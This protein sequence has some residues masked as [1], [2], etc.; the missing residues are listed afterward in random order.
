MIYP[1]L[2]TYVL[3][4]Y[5]CKLSPEM[6]NSNNINKLITYDKIKAECPDI[7]PF[8]EAVNGLGFLQAVHHFYYTK[9][10]IYCCFLHPSVPNFLANHY[11]AN[12]ADKELK[13][14][15]KTSCSDLTFGS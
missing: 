15:K 10:T 11:I 6:L 7:E 4:Q 5:L 1:I 2:T 12:L 9:E 3:L 14:F 13:F 8:P